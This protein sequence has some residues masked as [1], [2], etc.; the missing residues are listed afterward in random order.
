MDQDDPKSVRVVVD[1]RLANERSSR[2]HALLVCH[3]HADGDDDLLLQNTAA[4]AAV[5]SL[6][7]LQK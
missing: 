6:M 2:S 4:A 7:L 1:H 5:H 3:H